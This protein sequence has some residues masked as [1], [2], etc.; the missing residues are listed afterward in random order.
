MVFADS[1]GFIAA[2]DRR[3]PGHP[4]A[5]REWR[6]LAREGEAVVTTALVLAETVTHLRRRAGWEAAVR[7]GETLLRSRSIQILC[8]GREVLDAA[9][10]EFRRNA[11]PGLSLCDALSFVV[12]RDRGISLAL[13][14]DRHFATAGFATLRQSRSG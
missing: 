8:P 14:F 2:F 3:D 13:T 10:R 7:A 12:M 9:W 11:E 4:R 1:S 5:T 6:R